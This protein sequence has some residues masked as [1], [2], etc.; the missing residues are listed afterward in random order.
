M[1]KIHFETENRI[2]LQIG[3]ESQAFLTLREAVAAWRD[4][5]EAQRRKTRMIVLGKDG[6]ILQA[7]DIERLEMGSA[8]TIPLE[9]LN[10]ENDE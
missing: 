3:G 1:N 6:R 2:A 10:A 7:D 4:L 9:E 5:P 8:L